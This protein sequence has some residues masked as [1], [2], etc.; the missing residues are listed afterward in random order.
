MK[1]ITFSLLI[2]CFTF[3]TATAQ[4]EL[5]DGE[6]IL[7]HVVVANN[8]YTA[9]PLFSQTPP[10]LPF[11][12]FPGIYFGIDSLG[13]YEAT[14]TLT[15]NYWFHD[16]SSASMEIDATSFTTLGAVTLGSCDCICELEGFYLSTILAGDF[17]TRTFTYTIENTSGTNW[18]TITS[19]EGD[20]AVFYDYVLSID[21]SEK[22]RAF[23]VYPNPSSKELNIYVENTSIQTI[24]IFSV[25]GK[26]VFS[27]SNIVPNAI[28]ISHF[29]NGLY[30][31]EIISSE[32]HKYV[33]R[34]LK[35]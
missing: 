17:K 5:L 33:Q 6:W 16:A 14:A 25:A 26:N 30:F 35:N 7:D 10:C 12:Y 28:D 27:Y 1:K 11:D 21:D 20:T 9:P 19:P 31:V 8:T 24:K 18:L 23:I 15:F 4:Q 2:S 13:E 22:E 3:L 29:A 34:F 32:G